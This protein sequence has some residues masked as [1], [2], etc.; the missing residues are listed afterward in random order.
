MDSIHFSDDLEIL[1]CFEDLDFIY[2]KAV[3]TVSYRTNT[4]MYNVRI[5]STH[6]NNDLQMVSYKGVN[7]LNCKL[8]MCWYIT[9]I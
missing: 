6:P 7:V 9:I 8:H 1:E 5:R 4:I 2:H 3:T